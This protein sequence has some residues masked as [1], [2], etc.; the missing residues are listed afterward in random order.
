[1]IKLLCLLICGPLVICAQEKRGINFEH[2]ISWK[3]V[4]D[5]ARTEGKLIF[6]D[7]Y[8]SWCGP[9]KEMDKKVYLNEKVGSYMNEKFIS[10]K[11]RMDTSKN[12]NE[13][14]KSWYS[15]ARS[16]EYK[17]KV[18]AYPTLLFLA[19]DGSL[20]H[21]AAGAYDADGFISLAS[22]ALNPEK[23]YSKL[24]A[25]YVEG[26]RDSLV[27]KQLA[28]STIRF[29]D[30]ALGRQI[31][32]DFINTLR[33]NN[34]YTKE[35]ISFIINFTKS[36]NDKGFAMVYRHTN[37]VNKTMD[38]EGYAQGVVNYIITKEEIDP[39]VVIATNSGLD[40]NWTKI[41]INITKK[42]NSTYA[43]RAVTS[44]KVRW[45]ESKKNWP[46]YCKNLVVEVEKYGAD[47]W[48]VFK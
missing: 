17:F 11:V 27:M 42:Y 16:I 4:L 6:V 38:K 46:E 30:T 35:N 1:M 25:S 7:C 24:L 18:N 26:K 37:K 19:S 39:I 41:I 31:A 33:E 45:Y 9:C 47:L 2:G 3:Q 43:I 8:A 20:L 32:K 5:K 36:S 34:L 13:M 48:Y 15:D 40:P 12:D 10:I 22:D 14:E 28:I 29:G 44:A 23:Q 21:R